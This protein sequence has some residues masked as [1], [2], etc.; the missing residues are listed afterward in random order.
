MVLAQQRDGGD[1]TRGGRYWKDRAQ[2]SELIPG[3]EL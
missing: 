3:L 2:C 1:K